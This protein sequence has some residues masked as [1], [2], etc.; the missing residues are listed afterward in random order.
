MDSPISITDYLEADGIFPDH[1][2]ILVTSFITLQH[3]HFASELQ[4]VENLLNAGYKVE[5]LQCKSQLSS[6]FANVLHTKSQ[7]LACISTNTAIY[8]K[9]QTSNLSFVQLESLIPEETLVSFS[10]NLEEAFENGSY[11]STIAFTKDVNVSSSISQ[12]SISRNLRSSKKLY[13][14]L[15]YYLQVNEVSAIVT[16]NGR[17]SESRVCLEIGANSKLPVY[18]HE[19][20]ANSFRIFKGGDTHLLEYHK[21][22]VSRIYNDVQRRSEFLQMGNEFFRSQRYGNR[23]GASKTGIFSDRFLVGSLP[24]GFITGDNNISIFLTSEDEQSGFVDW[25]LPFGRSQYDVIE[26]IIPLLLDLN[27]IVWIRVH[28]NLAGRRNNSQIIETAKLKRKNVH[29][30]AAEESVD[31]Y[32]L[33]SES[34]NVIVFGSTIGLESTF[35]GVNTILL[36]RS[37]YEHLD[38]NRVPSSL[39]DLPGLLNLSV[40]DSNKENAVLVAAYFQLEYNHFTNIKTSPNDK[41]L[42]YRGFAIKPK[43]FS[44][45]CYHL[46]QFLRL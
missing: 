16:F 43:T 44:R 24:Q 26:S 4:I 1:K 34:S 41:F 38:V 27:Y 19:T 37:L 22:C 35:M 8:S 33:I 30:I 46:L 11:Q 18:C 7:C 13:T 28:P 40:S 14:Q 15:K 25:E 12:K 32:T 10:P 9:L 2:K 36:G 42:I 29:V 23:A 45:A 20:S 31:S 6:C 39:L 21:K 5:V 17:F 3:T